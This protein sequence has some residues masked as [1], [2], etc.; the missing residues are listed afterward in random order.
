MDPHNVVAFHHHRTADSGVDIVESNINST[1]GN[2]S[3]VTA[4]AVAAAAVQTSVSNNFAL[5]QRLNLMAATIFANAN[6][7]SNT[8]ADVDANSAFPFLTST[9]TATAAPV[10][11]I[12][13]TIINSGSNAINISNSAAQFHSVAQSLVQQPQSATAAMAAAAAAALVNLPSIAAAAVAASASTAPSN[14]AAEY[15]AAAAAAAQQAANVNT[16]NVGA[17]DTL[18]ELRHN[19]VYPTNFSSYLTTSIQGNV[20]N[21]SSAPTIATQPY[22]LISSPFCT[23]TSLN[24][25]TCPMHRFVPSHFTDNVDGEHQTLSMLSST[26]QSFPMINRQNSIQ[27]NIQQSAQQ[28]FLLY[29]AVENSSA[30]NRQRSSA[31]SSSISSTTS[32][33]M[34]RSASQ[35]SSNTHNSQNLEHQN[36]RALNE[37]LRNQNGNAQLLSTVILPSSSPSNNSDELSLRSRILEDS[38][39]LLTASSSRVPKLRRIGSIEEEIVTANSNLQAVTTT[40]IVQLQRQQQTQVTNTIMPFNGAANV[41]PTATLIQHNQQQEHHRLQQLQHVRSL[42]NNNENVVNPIATILQQNPPSSIT[43]SVTVEQFMAVI[44][45]ATSPSTR[46]MAATYAAMPQTPEPTTHC[47]V[48]YQSTA[49]TLIA[50]PAAVTACNCIHHHHCHHHHHHHT[51]CTVCQQQQQTQLNNQQQLQLQQTQQQSAVAAAVAAFQQQQS[52]G[53]FVTAGAS[54]TVRHSPTT[55]SAGASTAVALPSTLINI[56]ASLAQQTQNV[57]MVAQQQQN[58]RSA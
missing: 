25:S 46:A 49:A 24:Q 36:N 33:V 15:V 22:A 34:K 3:A 54:S 41:V 20:T 27:E 11:H 26:Q 23:T 37:S 45:A 44:S 4:A 13:P 40:A 53:H 31:L 50:T 32:R 8:V 51:I 2:L 55:A 14:T 47:A 30:Y 6:N 28:R 17:L 7:H 57:A 1:N 56:A 21:A 43:P 39:R 16:L 38:S 42:I 35:I 19:V 29:P 5:S 58:S 48:C 18:N 10:E 52:I 9:T 12:S